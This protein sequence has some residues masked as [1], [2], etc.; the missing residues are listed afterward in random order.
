MPVLMRAGG[1]EVLTRTDMKGLFD[2]IVMQV[3]SLLEQQVR[4]SNILDSSNKV[5][6]YYPLTVIL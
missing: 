4:D 5:S 6:V 2:P 1:T 3:I